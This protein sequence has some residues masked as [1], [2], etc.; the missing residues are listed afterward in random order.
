MTT[1]TLATHSASSLRK[2]RTITSVLRVGSGKFFPGVISEHG[3]GTQVRREVTVALQ[4]VKLVDGLTKRPSTGRG[5]GIFR[6]VVK[7]TK[8]NSEVEVAKNKL[9]AL[10]DNNGFIGRDFELG[11]LTWEATTN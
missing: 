3:S 8:G 11:I 9:N 2:R 10:F 4:N 7:G 6:G 5:H 1:F